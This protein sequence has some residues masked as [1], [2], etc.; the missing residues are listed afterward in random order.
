MHKQ[1]MAEREDSGLVTRDSTE[2]GVDQDYESLHF[3]LYRLSAS[4]PL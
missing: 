2:I 3:G 1:R 4:C